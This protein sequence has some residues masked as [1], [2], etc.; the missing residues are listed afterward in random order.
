MSDRQTFREM[1]VDRNMRE[2]A[3]EAYAAVSHYA[4]VMLH[5]RETFVNEFLRDHNTLQQQI[6]SL[7]IQC[8]V[9]FAKGQTYDARNEALRKKCQMI[10]DVLGDGPEA[11]AVPFI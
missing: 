7:F 11:W 10:V 2:E 4:N 3:K 8:L 6:G 5:D 9:K 1:E